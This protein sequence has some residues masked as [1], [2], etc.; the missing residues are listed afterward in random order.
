MEP[1][2]RLPQDIPTRGRLP[3]LKGEVVNQGPVWTKKHKNCWTSHLCWGRHCH[4]SS[5]TEEVSKEEGQHST[6]VFSCNETG[7]FG[8]CCMENINYENAQEQR[9]SGA[10][11]TDE[12]HTAMP[13][14]LGWRQIWCMEQR[15]HTPSQ[16]AGNS[17][18]ESV[19]LS[20]IFRFGHPLRVS[21]CA[22]QMERK[23]K[24]DKE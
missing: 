4:I 18:F 1:V 8:W 7:L 2:W 9:D 19:G 12:L 13:Q 11:R 23:Y 17:H 5:R 10:R 22:T 21:G 16:R 15:I 3:L 14:S 24:P 20:T 6:Q